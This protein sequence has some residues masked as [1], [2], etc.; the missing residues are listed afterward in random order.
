[1]KIMKLITFLIKYLC[2]LIVF[3]IFTML[4]NKSTIVFCGQSPLIGQN[5]K[6]LDVADLL[7]TVNIA[8]TGQSGTKY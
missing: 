4:L 2:L 7:T 8:I 5:I 6:K 1:M 3:F